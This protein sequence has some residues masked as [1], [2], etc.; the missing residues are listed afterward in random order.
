MLRIYFFS[1]LIHCI[2][3]W[4]V[5]DHEGGS[6]ILQDQLL[7]NIERVCHWLYV[8][9]LGLDHRPTS[10]PNYLIR[11]IIVGAREAFERTVFEGTPQMFFVCRWNG[12][13]ARWLIFIFVPFAQNSLLLNLWYYGVWQ[14]PQNIRWLFLLTCLRFLAL[15]FQVCISCVF[16]LRLGL[17][18]MSWTLGSFSHQLSRHSVFTHETRNVVFW[19]IELE[20]CEIIICS[21]LAWSHWR[22]L[23]QASPILFASHYFK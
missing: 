5:P 1:Q 9:V 19:K 4:N 8:H 20:P 11:W 22:G 12:L 7:L 15:V 21:R 10:Q 2:L 14:F 17:L 13:L 18:T 6:P 3:V 23:S 16:W